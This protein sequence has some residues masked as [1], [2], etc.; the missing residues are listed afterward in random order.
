MPNDTSSESPLRDVPNADLL[1]HRWHYSN[2]GH[3][4]SMEKS[5]QRGVDILQYTAVHGSLAYSSPVRW[6]IG[7][8]ESVQFFLKSRFFWCIRYVS[9]WTET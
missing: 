1:W 3:L 9:L 5:P 7:L 2:C 6:L 4:S 8:S